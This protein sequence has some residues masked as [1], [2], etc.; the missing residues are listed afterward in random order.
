MDDSQSNSD[1]DDNNQGKFYFDESPIYQN[2][3]ANIKDRIHSL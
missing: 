3:L 2:A 1:Q